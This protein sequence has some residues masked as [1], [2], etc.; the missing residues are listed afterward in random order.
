MKFGKIGRLALGLGLATAVVVSAPVR[1][2]VIVPA[3]AD[4]AELEQADST[5]LGVVVE[6][7]AQ[8]R[9]QMVYGADLLAAAGLT[10]GM[11]ITGLTFRID[12]LSRDGGPGHNSNLPAQTVA[13]FEIGM[14]ASNFAPGS[15]DVDF[16]DNRGSDFAI[17]R[18]GE[19]IIG[20][21][22]FPGGNLTGPN[23]WGVIIALA[24]YLYTGGDLLI[25]I[26]HDGFP[27]GGRFV[28]DSNHDPLAWNSEQI[29]ASSFNGTQS[30]WGS[31][32]QAMALYLQ[33][34]SG[35][36][37]GGNAVPAP[38]GLS[39]FGAALACMMG[40]A[41][42]GNRRRKLLPVRIKT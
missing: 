12:A 2:D 13:N 19:F 25:E 33:T 8:W 17:R 11:T 9:M 20:A 24:P 5:P 37:P 41:V 34:S 16:A 27:N 4:G 29:F 36:G 40:V 7:F 23:D 22:D 21:T 31:E 39:L 38:S 30:E 6:G 10:S 35:G 26:A 3:A 18:S 32:R 28:D 15:L 14:G 42:V 1:A